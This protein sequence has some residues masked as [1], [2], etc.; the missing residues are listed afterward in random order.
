MT[1]KE[2]KL[3]RG[4]T[5]RKNKH[6]ESIQIAF[7]FQGVRCRE[8]MLITPTKSNIQHAVNKLNEIR[9][10]IER[11]KFVYAEHFPNSE[12][13]KIFGQKADLTKTVLD[14]L[15][16]YQLRSIKRG[17]SPSTV[18]GYRKLK[19]SLKPLHDIPVVHLTSQILKKFVT[20]SNNSAKTLRNKFSYL[21][22]ALAEAITDGLVQKNPIDNLKLSN[23]V[24]RNDKINLKGR[25]IDIDP[26]RPDE[27]K[28]IY[29]KCRSDEINIVKLVFNTGMRSSEWSA[30]RWSDVHFEKKEIKVCVAVVFQQMKLPKSLA[31]IRTIP[32][33][34]D[35]LDA[36][37]KQKNNSLGNSEFVFTK[38]RVGKNGVI[39]KINPDSFRKHRWTRILKDA[40]VR[41]R[42][43]YQMRH[44]FATRHVSKGTHLW[45]LANW[46]G[47][48]SPEMI[49]RH[50]GA[51]IEDYQTESR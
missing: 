40:G 37:N 15:E 28:A 47:H 46:M 43:P 17:L 23:Y 29:A 21:R 20:S 25:H 31:G 24:Q 19:L 26:F 13:L 30:L 41:Y 38:K 12:K 18:E 35:A 27:V 4:V 34:E 8:S 5:I 1:T 6:G 44:T 39:E 48:K 7:T 14:Y 11:G 36:L 45:Q 22:A 10:K 50:Y 33:N 16:E 49:M 2:N 51:F 9:D 3:P 42:Y 32:L